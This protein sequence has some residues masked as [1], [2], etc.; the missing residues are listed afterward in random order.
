MIYNTPHALHKDQLQLIET[1]LL[2]VFK[3]FQNETTGNQTAPKFGQPQPKK[4][5]TMV[6]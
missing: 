3:H 2:M 4:D 5:Q 1:G 6:I